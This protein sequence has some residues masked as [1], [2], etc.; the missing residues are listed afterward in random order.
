MRGYEL[1]A[2]PTSSDRELPGDLGNVGGNL[3]RGGGQVDFGSAAR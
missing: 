3:D 1:A 2:V